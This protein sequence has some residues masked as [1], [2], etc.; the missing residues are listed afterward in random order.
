MNQQD[1]SITLPY[2]KL[3]VTMGAL[4]LVQLPPYA[5]STLRGA[6]SAATKS[7][8]CMGKQSRGCTQS[9]Q[10]PHE[11]FYGNLFETP[12]TLS[13]PSR[14]RSSKYSP[15]PV[16]ITPPEDG[17]LLYPG[18]T[19]SFSVTLFG[20]AR[21]HVPRLVASL[22]RMAQLGIGKNRG[23][24]GLKSVSDHYSKKTVWCQEEPDTLNTA[25]LSP[26]TILLEQ[27]PKVI[28]EKDKNLQDMKIRLFLET[29][30]LIKYKGKSYHDF[31]LP[32]FVQAVVDRMVLMASCHGTAPSYEQIRGLTDCWYSFTQEL[33]VEGLQTRTTLM[34]TSRFS[35]RQQRKHDLQGIRG[36]VDISGNIAPLLPMLDMARV[37]HVG[38]KIAFGFGQ[39][40]YLIKAT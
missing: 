39:I 34:S 13:T 37:T 21:H 23:K 9:C 29:P 18:D 40:D 16:L 20:Q 12:H 19:L 1:T 30:L 22:A 4:E 31:E 32:V 38:K 15:H 8:T 33:D 5:G 36:F 7:V 2:I 6:L 24:L 35:G 28:E 25:P 27:E 17:G 3:D 14:V 26:S 11:C 10:L